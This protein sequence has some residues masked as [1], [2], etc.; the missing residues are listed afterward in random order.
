MS[1]SSAERTAEPPGCAAAAVAMAGATVPVA[2][3]LT[4]APGWSGLFL[5]VFLVSLAAVALLGSVGFL[6][7]RERISV[8]AIVA[9]GF[10]TGSTG[11]ALGV[12]AGARD[13][14]DPTD[15]LLIFGYGIVG[16]GGALLTWLLLRWQMRDDRA[17]KLIVSGTLAAVLLLTLVL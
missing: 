4:I 5:P 1:D 3:V 17:E 10:A 11:P 13:S 16:I 15:L 8:P 14:L 9:G 7:I 2:A 6:W 12:L